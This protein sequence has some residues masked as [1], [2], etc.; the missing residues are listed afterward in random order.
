[1]DKTL[2]SL[3]SVFSLLEEALNCKKSSLNAAR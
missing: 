1:M 3:A 2:F